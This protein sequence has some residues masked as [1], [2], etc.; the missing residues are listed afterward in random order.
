VLLAT[1]KTINN[2]INSKNPIKGIHDNNNHNTNNTI[3]VVLIPGLSLHFLIV[4]IENI[5]II[6]RSTICITIII[7]K[8]A[9]SSP[10]IVF[11]LLSHCNI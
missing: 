10:N 7:V 5:N 6:I 8:K 3:I 2:A 1:I 4:L 11:S 9:I